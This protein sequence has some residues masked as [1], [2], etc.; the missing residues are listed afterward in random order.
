MED[1]S[2]AARPFIGGEPKQTYEPGR[3]CSHP[4]CPTVLSIYNPKDRCG[5]HDK[6]RVL[7]VPRKARARR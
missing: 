5:A 2:L 6:A 7:R 4:P 3:V 1:P